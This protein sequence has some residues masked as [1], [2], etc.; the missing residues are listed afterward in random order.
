MVAVNKP[1]HDTD[2]YSW[3]QSQLDALRRRSANELDWDGL[4]EE[5]AALG[6]SEIRELEQRFRVLQTHLLK[7]I[8][9]PERRGRSWRNSIENQREAIEDHLSLNP[10]LKP[11]EAQQFA[12][13]YRKA[14][15]DASSEMDMDLALI[16]GEAPF[17]LDEAKDEAWW[18]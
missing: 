1:L 14:R 2:F 11:H 9:Q 8:L 18:P 13:A 12:R 3:T 5:M 6:A 10:G 15:R 7:W 16:P 4:A 17:S